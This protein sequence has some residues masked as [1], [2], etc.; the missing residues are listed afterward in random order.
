MPCERTKGDYHPHPLQGLQLSHEVG[1]AGIPLLGS[2]LVC[3]RSAAYGCC[4]ESVAQT[5][6]VTAGH[7]DRLARIA[8]SVHRREEPVSGS[9]TG[10]D[11]PG[12]IPAVSRRSQ[13]HHQQPRPG[14]AEPWDRPPPVLLRCEGG[15]FLARHPLSPLHQSR[16]GPASDDGR[17]DRFYLVPGPHIWKDKGGSRREVVARSLCVA[18]IPRRSAECRSQELFELAWQ[19]RSADAGRLG[20]RR[21]GQGV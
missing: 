20:H 3:R 14:V 18:G 16:A 6:P 13:P 5:Q 21:G 2:G 1:Q 10:E 8:R 9:I 19:G 11:A 12:A 4:H 7:G 15:S 17:F